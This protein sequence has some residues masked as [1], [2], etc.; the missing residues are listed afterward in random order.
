MGVSRKQLATGFV[1]QADCNIEHSA[2]KVS[3]SSLSE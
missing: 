2:V 3:E 1:W